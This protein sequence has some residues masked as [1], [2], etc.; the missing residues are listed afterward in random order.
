M[1]NSTPKKYSVL[2]VLGVPKTLKP[3]KYKAFRQGTPKHKG[4]PA[5]CSEH[6]GCSFCKPRPEHAPAP[7]FQL[8]AHT[9]KRLYLAEGYA[10]AVCLYACRVFW[11]GRMAHQR[12]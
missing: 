7:L 4:A 5:R 8:I 6:K 1:A 10:L 9:A 12:G 11:R 3:F 2:S